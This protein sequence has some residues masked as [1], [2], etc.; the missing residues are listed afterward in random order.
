M[1]FHIEICRNCDY[2]NI[3]FRF[4]FAVAYYEE[5]NNIMDDYFGPEE[6]AKLWNVSVRQI[7]RLCKEGRIEGAIRFRNLWAIPKD[8]VKPTRTSGVKP[9][10]KSLDTK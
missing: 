4:D 3:I 2:N 5:Y 10:R 8:A 6:A 9:G 7:Q 1:Q